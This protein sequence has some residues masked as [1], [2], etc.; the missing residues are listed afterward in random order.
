MLLIL[1]F[2]LFEKEERIINIERFIEVQRLLVSVLFFLNNIAVVFQA[3]YHDC[4]NNSLKSMFDLL[5][6]IVLGVHQSISFL[7]Q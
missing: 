3:L 1:F 6:Y 2:L 4:C 5:V 7:R